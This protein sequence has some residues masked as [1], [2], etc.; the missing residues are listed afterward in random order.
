MV[1]W[2]GSWQFTFTQPASIQLHVQ[3]M[4][5]LERFLEDSPLQPWV[6]VNHRL[7]FRPVSPAEEG[8]SVTVS[9]IFN[10]SSLSMNWAQAAT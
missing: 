2:T 4:L 1:L 6:S 3:V 5:E 9:D 10:S 7:L 8:D